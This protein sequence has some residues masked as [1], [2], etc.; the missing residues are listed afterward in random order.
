MDEEAKLRHASV[1]KSTVTYA[2]GFLCPSC[3]TL[4]CFPTAELLMKHEETVHDKQTD[5]STQ[6]DSLETVPREH[7]FV[8]G[9]R[10]GKTCQYCAARIWRDG[11]TC[12]LCRIKCHDSCKSMALL[13]RD[14]PGFRQQANRLVQTIRKAV[15]GSKR[16]FV[17]QFVDLDLTYITARIIAM[18]FPASGLEAT[19]RNDLNDVAAV[20]TSRHGDKFMVFNVSDKAYNISKLR[21][22]VLDFGWPDHMAPPIERLCSI[23]LSMDSWLS[24]DPENVAVVHCKGGKGR[25]GVAIAAYIF[26]KRLFSRAEDAMSLFAHKRFSKGLG[27]E[28]DA[29]ISNPSQRRYVEYFQDVVEGVW[30]VVPHPLRI[31]SI[32]LHPII[33]MDGRQGFRPIISIYEDPAKPP[34]YVTPEP[35]QRYIEKDRYVHL[36]APEDGI[37]IQGDVTVKIV[38]RSS[39]GTEYSL[40]RVQFHT[41]AVTSYVYTFP[42]SQIDD[43]YKD[44]RVPDG[45]ELSFVFDE[46]IPLLQATSVAPDTATASASVAAHFSA[47]THNDVWLP[48]EFTVEFRDTDDEEEE[49]DDDE[50]DEEDEEQGVKEAVSGISEIEGDS[51]GGKVARGYDLDGSGSRGDFEELGQVPLPTAGTTS[52]D[53]LDLGFSLGLKLGEG[54]VVN[55]DSGSDESS[56]ESDKEATFLDVLAGLNDSEEDSPC[57]GSE[58]DHDA[59]YDATPGSHWFD[60]GQPAEELREQSQVSSIASGER[61][62]TAEREPDR[63]RSLNPFAEAFDDLLEEDGRLNKSA[64]SDTFSSTNPFLSTVPI[65]AGTEHASASDDCI[66]S[67]SPLPSRDVHHHRH[68]PIKRAISEPV[69]PSID[70]GTPWSLSSSVGAGESAGVVDVVGSHPRDHEGCN[71]YLGTMSREGVERLLFDKGRNYMYCVTKSPSTVGEFTLSV[72][73]ATSV[74]HCGIAWNNERKWFR[75]TSRG[76]F[77]TLNSVVEFYRKFPLTYYGSK[78]VRLGDALSFATLARCLT[79]SSGSARSR[80]VS[81]TRS[82]THSSS[83]ASA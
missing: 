28:T 13:Q 18:S 15:T 80:L 7:V 61:G 75:V 6:P 39:R 25:T 29:G 72:R 30:P 57:C 35:Y 79:V 33:P 49:E 41:A 31:K 56:S 24:A 51:K 67:A 66:T 83:D 65:A 9:C 55:S 26:Y 69:R 46:S 20:L 16:R 71:W 77:S 2:S 54:A 8:A 58:G 63:P 81:L 5:P 53:K 62:A 78:P 47:M 10:R 38:H 12:M 27:S 44:K 32:L 34:I 59:P 68:R 23:I 70:T 36:T 76:N 37:E 64:C 17:T 48:S 82:R 42:K 40:G 4:V 52:L 3:D 60:G 1:R 22:Q 43:M 50:E 19:Y 21:H 45:F 74:I 73:C 14:C 11:V